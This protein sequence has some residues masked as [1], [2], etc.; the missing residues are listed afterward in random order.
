MDVWDS[1]EDPHRQRVGIAV[2]AGLLIVIATAALLVALG[3]A[4]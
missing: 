2:V 1:Y 3:G 4:P